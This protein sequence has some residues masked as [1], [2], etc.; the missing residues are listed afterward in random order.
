MASEITTDV[1]TIIEANV[2]SIAARQS[3]Y[4]LIRELPFTERRDA[5]K[6][7]VAVR[8]FNKS[9]KIH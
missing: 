4:A 2:T 9:S 6:A 5:A 8:L 1:K 7:I 3:I